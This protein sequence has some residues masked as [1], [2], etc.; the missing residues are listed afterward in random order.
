[1]WV[2]ASKAG[3]NLDQDSRRNLNVPEVKQSEIKQS[4]ELTRPGTKPL[5][6]LPGRQVGTGKPITHCSSKLSAPQ[7]GIGQ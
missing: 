3:K 5:G 2:A 1:M 4:G 7:K 6:N